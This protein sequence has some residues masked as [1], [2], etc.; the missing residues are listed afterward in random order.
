M[1]SNILLPAFSSVR[2]IWTMRFTSVFC[3]CVLA[4]QELRSAQQIIDK[5]RLNE[6]EKIITLVLN[7]WRRDFAESYWLRQ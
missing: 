2:S 7:G 3:V 1:A 5:E 4:A 6:S